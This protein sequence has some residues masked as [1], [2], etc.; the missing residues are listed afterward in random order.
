MV[1]ARRSWSGQARAPEGM[2]NGRKQICRIGMAADS[3]SNGNTVSDDRADCVG[4]LRKSEPFGIIAY[5]QAVWVRPSPH[6]GAAK[7]GAETSREN[8]AR[9]RL[10]AKLGKH[11]GCIGKIGRL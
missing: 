2:E 10:C 1:K 7:A 11:V 9:L 8:A 5:F 3:D 4:A 6:R